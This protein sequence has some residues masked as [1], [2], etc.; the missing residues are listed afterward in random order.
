MTPE[1][2]AQVQQMVQR[3]QR[4]AGAAPATATTPGFESSC[5]KWGQFFPDG[6]ENVDQLA[7]HLQQQMAAM[8]SLL[9]SMTPEMRQSSIR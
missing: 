4:A 8:Q 7:E 5:E 1:M 3:P 2:M 6:I 9:D